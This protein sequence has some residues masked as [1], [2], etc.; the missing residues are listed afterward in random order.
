MSL[1]PLGEW[2][3]L[4]YFCRPLPLHTV[5]ASTDAMIRASQ[6][7]RFWNIDLTWTNT[8]GWDLFRSG[9][10]HMSIWRSFG[11]VN[12]TN[13]RCDHRWEW[14]Q[15]ALAHPWNFARYPS[16]CHRAE[17][18]EVPLRSRNYPSNIVLW[19]DHLVSSLAHRFVWVEK[20]K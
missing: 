20:I 12:G 19:N 16:R 8:G 7:P 14:N 18:R 2:H 11:I 15:N 5:P 3:G 13:N 10:T 9:E 4:K 1:P 17:T 6:E